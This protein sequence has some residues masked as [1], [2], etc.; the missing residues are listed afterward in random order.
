MQGARD[1]ARQA[2]GLDALVKRDEVALVHVGEHLLAK[3]LIRDIRLEERQQRADGASDDAHVRD[4]E[5]GERV[6]HERNDLDLA[7]DILPADELDAELR[8]LARLAAEGALLS[9]DRRLV[10]QARRKAL[11]RQALGGE[12]RDGKREVRA[13]HEEAI[14]R[15]EE[16]ERRPLD[17]AGSFEH[18]AVLKQRGLHGH[19][20]LGI[21]AGTHRVTNGL[22]GA[23]LL[24][25]NVPK[26][27]GRSYDHVLLPLAS[28]TNEHV[29]GGRRHPL[30]KQIQISWRR[31][32]RS[33]ISPT[34]RALT[35]A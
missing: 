22:T 12:A 5:G 26:S 34:F 1:G 27:S 25:Q 10:A 24:R 16:L 19:V 17:A 13:Q 33:P 28:R 14:V 18:G 15:V 9:N 2:S 20:S 21:K 6:R 7:R 3:G 8:E 32:Y 29:I 23:C 35:L 30:R 4:L 31:V 11:S